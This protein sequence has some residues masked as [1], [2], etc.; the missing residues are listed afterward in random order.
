MEKQRWEQ[1]K[2][3]RISDIKQTLEIKEQLKK[4]EQESLKQQ[5]Q[6]ELK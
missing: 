3:Q 6:E 4:Q 2:T 5:A 1:E